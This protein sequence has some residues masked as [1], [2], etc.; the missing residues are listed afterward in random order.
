[1]T[2]I[3]EG[4]NATMH[5]GH[6]VLQISRIVALTVGLFVGGTFVHGGMAGTPH[7]FSGE[8]WSGGEVCI[9]C[10]ISH[11]DSKQ[12]FAWNHAVPLDEVFVTR[13]GAELGFAS[14]LC[15]GCHDGQTALDSFGE[16]V[17]KV[18]MTGMPVIGRDLRVDHPVGVPYPVSDASYKSLTVVGQALP[19]FDDQ[20][21]CSTCHDP[22]DNSNGKYLRVD[23]RE[24]CQSCHSVW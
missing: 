16:T 12:G 11:S 9:P 8:N 4:E 20:V 7:D 15:L 14:L 5:A 23:R 10:H 2:R 6:V 22:H 24:L 3:K 13:E 17:G 19:L 21:E 1:M 18:V